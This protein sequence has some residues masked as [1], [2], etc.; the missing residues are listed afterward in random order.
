MLRLVVRL[1]RLTLQIYSCDPVIRASV[2]E[3]LSRRP[4]SRCHLA[5]ASAHLVKC[6]TSASDRWWRI[7][8]LR[9]IGI[10]LT[11][12]GWPSEQENSAK[13]TNQRVNCAFTTSPFSIHVHHILPTSEFQHSYSWIWLIFY[14]NQWIACVRMVSV[15][16]AV[17]RFDASSSGNLSE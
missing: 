6:A 10:N 13:L 16:N 17:H 12:P 4:F 7:L 9:V 15:M 14:R 11:N 1:L 5:T 3:T 2:L 8:Q